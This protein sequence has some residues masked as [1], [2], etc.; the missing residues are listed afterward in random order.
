MIQYIPTE[1]PTM[2]TTSHFVKFEKKKKKE[3]LKI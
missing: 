3:K 2:A 1:S